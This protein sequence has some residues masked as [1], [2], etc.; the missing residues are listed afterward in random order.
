[1][2]SE[3][4]IIGYVVLCYRGGSFPLAFIGHEESPPKP[5]KVLF[6][7]CGRNSEA[8]IFPTRDEAKIVVAASR[9]FWE[10]QIGNYIQ[11]NYEI[12]GL[13]KP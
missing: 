11:F 1:M 5:K 6:N 3:K 2:K 13:T 9:E 4:K 7:G 10:K 8:T 12:V